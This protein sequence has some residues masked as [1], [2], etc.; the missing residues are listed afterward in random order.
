[1]LHNTYDSLSKAELNHFFALQLNQI[2]RVLLETPQTIF[3]SQSQ[4][5]VFGLHPNVIAV[6]HACSSRPHQMGMGNGHQG[7]IQTD[8]MVRL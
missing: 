8:E 5:G 7:L 3:V 4:T 2:A 1:M 6:I